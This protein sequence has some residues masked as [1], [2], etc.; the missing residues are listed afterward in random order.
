VRRTTRLIPVLLSA[1]LALAIPVP[2]APTATAAKVV[3][4]VSTPPFSIKPGLV[5]NDPTGSKAARLRIVTQVEKAIDHAPKGSTIRIANYLFDLK[6]PA[7]KLILAQRRGVHVQLLID[8][9]PLS[10]QTKRVRAAFGTSTKHGSYVRRCKNGCM[11]SQPGVMHAKFYLFSQSGSSKWVSMVSSA[12]LYTGNSGTSWNNQHTIVGDKVLYNS[13]SRYFSDMIKDKDRPNYYRTTT[14]GKYKLYFFPRAAKPG[15]KD[16]VLLDVLNHVKCT[17]V[18]KGYGTS[19]R[20]T[21]VRVEQ[22]GWTSARLDIAKRL[23][24]LHNAGCNVQVINNKFKTSSVIMRT[25]LKRS[26]KHG[27]MPVYN[28]GIDTNGNGK[29]DKY[30]HHKV[31]A[32]SGN[33]FGKSNSKVVFTG[34]ANFSGKATLSNNELILRVTDNKTFDAYAANFAYIRH[35]WTKKVKVAPNLNLIAD[36]KLEA[37]L[38]S[39]A[40]AE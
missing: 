17:G 34:S 12:N 15:S 27:K 3:P 6:S 19:A 8:D 18:A 7:T 10:K 14:S 4:Q 2:L 36:R 21:M 23:W 9:A 5:F 30:M 39:N 22:W 20:R 11:S 33:L 1:A 37:S 29:R 24:K 16:I 26:A 32:I 35:G 40:A 13:L 38:E 28:A 31:V 25:L